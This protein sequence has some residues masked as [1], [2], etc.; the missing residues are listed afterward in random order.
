[1][2]LNLWFL[3]LQTHATPL[4]NHMSL[5]DYFSAM[6]AEHLFR[7]HWRGLSKTRVCFRGSCCSISIR[8]TG[9]WFCVRVS[10]C[11]WARDLTPNCLQ[12][13][14]QGVWMEYWWD[15]LHNRLCAWM[16]WVTCS[17]KLLWVGSRPETP[18]ILSTHHL[19]IGLVCY[20]LFHILY[21]IFL[22]SFMS[23]SSAFHLLMPVF[24]YSLRV[25]MYSFG[26][27][28]ESSCLSLWGLW[29]P[30]KLPPSSL[31]WQHTHICAVHL[32]EVWRQLLVQ[33]AMSLIFDGQ[34]SHWV[35]K[36]NLCTGVVRNYIKVPYNN[37]SAHSLRHQ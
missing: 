25:D 35:G 14:C 26:R 12:W 8:R 37:S 9:G 28:T 1:M 16:W 24:L 15:T 18:W 6:E 31:L 34:L 10:N 36:L 5:F 30:S 4:S 22:I 20:F 17:V 33:T 29:D 2:I 32:S 3:G 11:P 7:S 23:F 13:L 19:T 21:I 27:K